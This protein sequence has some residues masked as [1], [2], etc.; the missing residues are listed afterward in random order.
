MILG[1]KYKLSELASIVKAIEFK[2]IDTQYAERI[3]ID[4]RKIYFGQDELFIALRGENWDAH[5]FL[6]EAYNKGIRSFM[7][8]ISCDFVFPSDVT[9]IYVS[10]TLEALQLWA[11][12]HRL[13]YSPKCIAITGS[14]GKTIVKEWLFSLLSVHFSVIRSPK[15]YNSQIGVALSLLQINEK[16]EIAIIE[17]G[18]SRPNEMDKLEKMIMPHIGILTNIGSAHNEGFISQSH[19]L[20]EKLKLFSRVQSFIFRDSDISSDDKSLF[21]DNVIKINWGEDSANKEYGI[22]EVEIDKNNT[23]LSLR[24]NGK[25]DKYRLP[26]KLDISVDNGIHCIFLLKLLGL[27]SENIQ[28]GLNELSFVSM[29]LEQKKGLNNS[30]IINDIYNSDLQSLESALEF[31][32]N[33]QQHD[34]R[35]VVLS[36]ILESGLIAEK[37]INRV[38]LLIERSNIHELICVGPEFWK[39]KHYL[40][41]ISCSV[42]FF[43]DTHHFIDEM[44]AYDFANKAILLKGAR[45][46]RFESILKLLEYQHHSTYLEINLDALIH[47]LRSYRKR[48]KPKTSIMA[49]VKASSYGSG[50]NEIV[51][52]LQYH[53]VDY[54]A[55]AYLD[56]GIEL[57][58]SGIRLPIMI[59]NP[60]ITS[61]ETMIK[62]QLEP[63]VYSHNMLDA[64]LRFLKFNGLESYPIHIKLDTGMHR[65]GFEVKDLFNLIDKLKGFSKE[66]EIKSI[67]SHLKASDD[68]GESQACE[69]QFVLFDKMYS[70]IQESLSIKPLKHM[71]NS[72]GIINY[73]HY[74]YDMV[75]LGIG[76]YGIDPSDKVQSELE[77]VLSLKSR[78][79]QVKNIKKGEYIGYGNKNKLKN[80]LKS[81]TIS[82]GYA[83]GI[84]RLFGNGNASFS[85]AGNYYPT[86]GSI[87]MDMSMLDLEQTDIQEG[88]EVIIFNK[89]QDILKLAE[90][91]NTIPYEILTSISERVPKIYIKEG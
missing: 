57:R 68:V 73:S 75:R 24:Y 4:S 91:I 17:A 33:Q 71:L 82:I 21:S 39:N 38:R 59:M 50:K 77:N 53:K 19:K 78:V 9:V 2:E 42:R 1:K 76:L 83:D 63:E 18:I 56:E 25:I 62:Y 85:I 15:S 7:I 35:I 51:N 12:S 84:S 89:Y 5:E 86:I 43:R 80:N 49:V 32:N 88:D 87:C 20:K 64:L 31:L 66:V 14:N 72:A 55:V 52:L 30:T 61:Y 26:F 70:E 11:M 36:D 79:S 16:H 69:D 8:N 74:Q 65:L 54:L 47:N 37:L 3:C 58:K 48:L 28:K 81:A 34:K 27:S 41:N 60:D 45:K 13:A 23:D 90:S 29:R 46:F 40:S 22:E 67:L 10:D 6:G 44:N